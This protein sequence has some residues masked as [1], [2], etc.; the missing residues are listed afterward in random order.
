MTTAPP[1]PRPDAGVPYIRP[2]TP[3]TSKKT[4]NTRQKTPYTNGCHH[5]H[6]TPGRGVFVL[7]TEPL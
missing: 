1:A 6:P 3:N 7:V 2:T 5:H 4:P